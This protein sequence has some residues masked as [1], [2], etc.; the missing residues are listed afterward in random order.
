LVKNF[1]AKGIYFREDNFTLNLKRTEEFCEKLIKKNINI[2]WACETRVDNM[3]EDLLRLMSTAGCRG[4]Y[5][6]VESGSQRILDMLNKKITIEQIK[7]T[8]NCCK[9]YNIRTYCSLITGMPGETYEDYVLTKKLMEELKPYTYGFNVFV[10]IPYSSLYRYTLEN[11]LYEH[12]DDIG[13]VYPPGYDVKA[14]FFYGLDSKKLVDYEFKQRMDFDKRLL[15]EQRRKNL[16]KVLSVIKNK[17]SQRIPPVVKDR[18]K[19][20]LKHA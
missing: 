3:S 9:K 12:I 19:R 10:G 16:K 15:K 5:L 18:L 1:D 7:S 4:V 14:K 20:I 6:G 2:H 8:I 13:L 17:I 11:N